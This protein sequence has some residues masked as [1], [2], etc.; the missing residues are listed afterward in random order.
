MGRSVGKR[1]RHY[2]IVVHSIATLFF[3][4]IVRIIGKRLII[5]Q[6]FNKSI[7]IRKTTSHF[8]MRGCLKVISLIL[9]VVKRFLLKLLLMLL[10]FHL[11]HFLFH[12]KRQ[13]TILFSVLYRMDVNKS[14]SYF[15]VHT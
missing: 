8:V 1:F 13:Y 7:Q 4:Y 14:N 11:H 12:Q 9:L 5:L 6:L 3:K 10:I 15:R 2:T